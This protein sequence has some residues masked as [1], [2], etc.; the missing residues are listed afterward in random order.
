MTLLCAFS[1]DSVTGT[2]FFEKDN[3]AS[4]N[5]ICDLYVDMLGSFFE[6]NLKD[7]EIWFEQNGARTHFKK[8]NGSCARNVPGPLIPLRGRDLSFPTCSPDLTLY[9]FFL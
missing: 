4:V 5:I 6:L 8:I 9:D 3:G 2:Y 7:D 1:A